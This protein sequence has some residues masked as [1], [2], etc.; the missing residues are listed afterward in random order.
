[1]E[2]LNF[3]DNPL[4]DLKD[5]I[6]RATEIV[7]S[8]TQYDSS[9]QYFQNYCN[10]ETTTDNT[11]KYETALEDLYETKYDGNNQEINIEKSS[12]MNFLDDYMT[13]ESSIEMENEG[14][15][16]DFADCNMY[17]ANMHNKLICKTIEE[18]DSIGSRTSVQNHQLRDLRTVNPDERAHVNSAPT[19]HK[20]DVANLKTVPA[21][22]VDLNTILLRPNNTIKCEICNSYDLND[23]RRHSLPACLNNLKLTQSPGLRKIRAHKTVSR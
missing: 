3:S 9:T 16:C 6:D 18:V 20:V 7:R 8:G 21:K 12:G 14:K 5:A 15:V 11:Q 13:A 1:M 23:L 2:A 10:S 19:P 22:S 17:D 4:Q